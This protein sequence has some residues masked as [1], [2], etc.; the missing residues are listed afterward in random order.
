[1]LMDTARAMF[2][3]ENK[4]KPFTM[5][6]LWE[7]FREQRK[8]KNLYARE[9]NKRT[10]ISASGEYT[11]SSN[12]QETEDERDKRE[13]R[14]EGQKKAKDRAKGKGKLQHSEDKPSE[15]MLLFHDAIGK[16]S[17]ALVQIAE[18]SKERTKMTKM[19]TYLNLLEKDTSMYNE[20]K[21][22]RHEQV[23]DLLGKELFPESCC[24]CAK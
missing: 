7:K 22:R 4:E 9:N 14:P 18:A 16:R 10:K 2:K 8:W 12:N 13:K 1:M 3:G 24:L 5:E 23:L 20:A 11:S 17:A 21:L 6:Y 15:D 19:Q